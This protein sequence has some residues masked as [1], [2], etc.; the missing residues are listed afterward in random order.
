[1]DKKYGTADNDQKLHRI[2]YTNGW[3]GFYNIFSMQ[4]AA[5][6]SLKEF[7]NF[8]SKANGM[9]KRNYSFRMNIMEEI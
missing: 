8:I 1:L 4:T 2:G 6:S 7:I 9:Y 5:I 3:L